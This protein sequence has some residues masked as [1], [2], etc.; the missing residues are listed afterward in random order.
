MQRPSQIHPLTTLGTTDNDLEIASN[1]GP[2]TVIQIPRGF[3]RDPG[4]DTSSPRIY[5]HDVLESKVVAERS[6]NNLDSHGHKLPALVADVCLVTAGTDIVVVG[7]INIETELF[8]QRA[9]A[10]EVQLAVARIG[11][12]HGTNF[13][14]GWHEPEHVLSQPVLPSAA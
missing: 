2:L 13:D 12:I 14:S 6:S 5:P 10:R 11:R 9:E 1:D 3:V 7:Q 8:G 4:V